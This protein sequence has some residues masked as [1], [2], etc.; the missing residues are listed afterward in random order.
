MNLYYIFVYLF[1]I[2]I[3]LFSLIINMNKENTNFILSLLLINL[4]FI[5]PFI[6]LIL[7][8]NYDIA[9]DFCRYS[10]D[11]D[12]YEEDTDIEMYESDME[13]VPQDNTLSSV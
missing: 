2:S 9:L 10:R 6:Y 1:I 13:Y 7:N 8:I 5:M 11:D 12:D 4:F 3:V